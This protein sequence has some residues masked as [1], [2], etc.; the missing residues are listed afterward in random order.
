MDIS[1]DVKGD[2][3]ENAQLYFNLE[4]YFLRYLSNEAYDDDSVLM[5]TLRS[6][7]LR[8][9]ARATQQKLLDEEEWTSL[10][11]KRFGKAVKYDLK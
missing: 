5:V 8:A 11:Q 4:L 3:M 7:D 9:I 10:S 6:G 2:K 1:G